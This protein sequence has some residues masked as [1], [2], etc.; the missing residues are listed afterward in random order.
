MNSLQK[1]V[2]FAL[3][4][5]T[6]CFAVWVAHQLCSGYVWYTPP[7]RRI[8]MEI[9]RVQRAVEQARENGRLELGLPFFYGETEYEFFK[10]QQF[11][12]IDGLKGIRSFYCCGYCGRAVLPRESVS[13]LARMSDLE[14]IYI[15]NVFFQPG[16][17]S[18]LKE[19]PKLEKLSFW[20][21]RFDADSLH[22]LAGLPELKS[23]KI[24]NPFPE[25]A[26]EDSQSSLPSPQEQQRLVE[27]LGTFSQLEKLEL[28]DCFQAHE[29]TLK[30]LLP[31]A[32]ITFNDIGLDIP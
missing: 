5:I 25:G 7:A 28:H 15:Q 16:A 32:K 27:I 29:E 30:T 18:E 9:E 31:H 22:T 14:E 19:M 13:V 6:L 4:S 12:M 10:T 1:F 26:G 11:A 2:F 17:L 24:L 3:L 8:E 20:S 21:C 23:L